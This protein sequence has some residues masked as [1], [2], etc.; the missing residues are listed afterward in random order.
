M[1]RAWIKNKIYRGGHDEK[2]YEESRYVLDI[3]AY[4]MYRYL[5][6]AHVYLYTG[7]INAGYISTSKISKSQFDQ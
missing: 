5:I 3:N 4:T 6:K 7:K 1:S 2:V